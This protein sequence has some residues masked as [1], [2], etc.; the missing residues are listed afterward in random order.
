MKMTT[1]NTHIV[2]IYIS[3]PVPVIEQICRQDCMEN[4]MCVTVDPT[5]FIYT[6]GEETG[7]VIGLLN[8]PRFPSSKEAINARARSLAIKLLEG[9]HQR[10]ALIVSS[11]TTEL[12][13]QF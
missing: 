4:P 9:T 10:N 3:G 13:S 5:K 12:V 11:E 8:Y 6:G 2:R 7:A 1:S